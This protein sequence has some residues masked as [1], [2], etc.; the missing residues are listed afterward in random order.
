M[1]T[2]VVLLH[3]GFYGCG[4][5]AG[6][7]NR[8]F[9][10][11]LAPLLAPGCRLVVMP[12]WVAEDSNEYDERWHRSMRTLVASVGGAVVPLDNGAG[13]RYRFGSVAN[14]RHVA[15]SSA[16]RLCAVGLDSRTLVIAFDVPFLE[17]PRHLGPTDAS[18]VFVPRGA[19][20]LYQSGHDELEWE[21]ECYRRMVSC[22][23]RIG[24][25][26]AFMGNHLAS[27]CGMPR[28]MMIP[29]YDG[30]T[31]SE[32]ADQVPA[33]PLPV[34]AT[35]GFMLSMGRA[36][37]YKGFDDLLDALLMLRNGGEEV[38]HLVMAAVTEDH[39]PSQYQRHLQH[40]IAVERMNVT[41]VTRFSWGV[42]ALIGHPSLRAVIVPSRVE[43][44]GR[45]PMEVYSHP[46]ASSVAVAASAAGGLS[47][48]V[49]EGQTGFTFPPGS[50]DLLAHAI[51]RAVRSPTL[52][53]AQL[54]HAGQRL[55]LERHAYEA[56]VARFL[57]AAAPEGSLRA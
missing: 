54:H 56:N 30:V 38:P 57:Q 3:D 6:V 52:E 5:G 39:E 13:G 19:L 51:V 48:V 49:I 42:R 29:V 17:V 43:P 31:G 33:M 47:E 9:L 28:A 27:A 11:A 14:W 8:R 45:I 46:G 18:V 37:P 34:P 41:V 36:H 1:D 35:S 23:T 53:R 20:A 2:I 44:F 25:I 15:A 16:H 55:I 21:R 10:E 24:L 22:G 7:S 40:R 4:T 32:W 26:S 50:S 12:V